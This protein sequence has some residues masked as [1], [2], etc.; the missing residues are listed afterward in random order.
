MKTE[1]INQYGHAWRVFERLVSDFDAAAWL[2]TGRKTITPARLS[3]HLLQADM[4]Y[5]KIPAAA[6]PLASGKPINLNWET[7]AVEELP[8]QDD[9]LGGLNQLKTRTE[10]WLAEMDFNA[11]NTAFPWA[12]ETNLGLALF[13]LRHML[14]HLGELSSLLNESKNGEVEDNYVKAL[15][16][17]G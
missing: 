4:Y 14:Y 3:L 8:S 1:F 6:V 11:A 17:A 7:A 13:L 5:L 12:G 2:A 10:T 15:H 9:I 16:T